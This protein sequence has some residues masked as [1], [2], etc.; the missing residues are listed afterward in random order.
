[1]RLKFVR[2]SGLGDVGPEML[3]GLVVGLEPGAP[4]HGKWEKIDLD[5]DFDVV[6]GTMILYLQRI[7]WI[8]KN[9]EKRPKDWEELLLITYYRTKVSRIS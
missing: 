2:K 1:M 7:F 3:G 4:P 9:L 8:I 6:C 5:A